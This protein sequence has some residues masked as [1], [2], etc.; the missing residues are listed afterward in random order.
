[1]VERRRWSPL[2]KD[3]R[4]SLLKGVSPGNTAISLDIVGDMS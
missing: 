3:I 1:M 4:T 2:S